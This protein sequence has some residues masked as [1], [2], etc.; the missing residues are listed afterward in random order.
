MDPK[1][2]A[3]SLS[4]ALQDVY[5]LSD[6][7]SVAMAFNTVGPYVYLQSS[8]RKNILLYWSWANFYALL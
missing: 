3:M 7:N 6:G 8:S 4:Q 1:H 2:I 5:G